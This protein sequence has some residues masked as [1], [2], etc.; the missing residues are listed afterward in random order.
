MYRPASDQE[1]GLLRC[2]LRADIEHIATAIGER[3]LWNGR[4]I[5]CANEH[6]ETELQTY[7]TVTK[8]SYV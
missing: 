1:L 4:L 3:H 2:E 5:G 6:G 8:Q 7:P